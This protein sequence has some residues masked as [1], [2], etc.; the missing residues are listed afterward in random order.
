MIKVSS[1][2]YYHKQYTEQLQYL[3]NQ[4]LE[5]VITLLDTSEQEPIIIISGDHG[6][7]S[8]VPSSET[9]ASIHFERMHILNALYLPG[10]DDF[11]IQADHT[12]VNTFRVILNEYFGTDY[13]MLPNRSYSS[14]M[15]FPYQF[16]D[17]TE[18]ADISPLD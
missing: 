8:I 14:S 10:V 4:V 2:A 6:P 17:V 16:N 13:S 12:P 1:Q 18:A 15:L 7:R 3:S 5:T 9:D 11:V